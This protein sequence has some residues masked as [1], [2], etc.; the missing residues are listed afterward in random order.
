MALCF[1]LWD[2]FCSHLL[3]HQFGVVVYGGSKVVECGI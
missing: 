1:Q 3:P 2:E